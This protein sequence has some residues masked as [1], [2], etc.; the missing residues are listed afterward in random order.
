MK[1]ETK[2]LIEKIAI[3]SAPIFTLIM[4][5]LPWVA[6]LKY[7]TT[8]RVVIAHQEYASYIE[9]LKTSGNVFAKVLMYISLVGI[10]ATI[11]LYALSFFLKDKEKLLIKIGAM[12]LLASTGILFLT[13][14][15]SNF[16]DVSLSGAVN[17]SWVDFM[18]LPYAL[19]MIY[20][21]ASLIYFI[22]TNKQDKK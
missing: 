8:Y 13:L 9:V 10:I 7:K 6:I 2:K 5:L 14:I 18:T 3:V 4:Y 20:N 17:Y 21:V 22:K 15:E 19:L 12:T 16:K 1:E 11:T